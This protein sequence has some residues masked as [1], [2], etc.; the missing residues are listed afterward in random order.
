YNETEGDD[1]VTESAANPQ[2]NDASGLSPTSRKRKRI[3]E[4]HEARKRQREDEKP[5]NITS[6]DKP[7]D[8]HTTSPVSLATGGDRTVTDGPPDIVLGAKILE[9]DQNSKEFSDR[10]DLEVS[11]Y[12]KDHAEKVHV[13]GDD[14]DEVEQSEESKIEVEWRVSN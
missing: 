9:E 10:C 7:E 4:D 14:I 12:E 13:F 5:F 3:S 2:S 8:E 6:D 11:I 1:T